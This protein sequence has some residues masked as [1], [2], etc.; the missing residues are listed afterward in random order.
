MRRFPGRL[1]LRDWMDDASP[2][3][4]QYAPHMTGFIVLNSGYGASPAQAEIDLLIDSG[5][6]YSVLNPRDAH[7]LLGDVLF[8]IDFANDQTAVGVVGMGQGRVVT[9]EREVEIVLPDEDG[10]DVV[11]GLDMQI[12]RPE[13][14]RVARTGNWQL[15]S[16]LGRDILEYLDLHLSYNTPYVSLMVP[17]L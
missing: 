17:D 3:T 5:S 2:R 16:L 15:P 7:E 10:D 12:A 6:D 13:P 11:I 9:I 4:A 8:E 1:K 14:F